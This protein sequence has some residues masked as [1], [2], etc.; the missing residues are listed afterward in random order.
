MDKL[1]GG[2]VPIVCIAIRTSLLLLSC[3]FEHVVVVVILD[4]PLLSTIIY[5]CRQI[6]SKSSHREE[7]LWPCSHFFVPSGF[8]LAQLGMLCGAIDVSEVIL[9]SFIVIIDARREVNACDDE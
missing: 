5:C 3:P 2:C 7:V 6:L 4:S 8:M 9:F 1:F